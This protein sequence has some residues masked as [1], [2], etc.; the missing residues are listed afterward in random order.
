MTAEVACSDAIRQAKVTRVA[1]S[2]LR[3]LAAVDLKRSESG[4]HFVFK[5]FGQSLDIKIS[6]TNLSTKQNFPHVTFT[7]WV[8]HVV[9][10][11][12]LEQLVGVKD[13][14]VMRP[15]LATFWDRFMKL[16]PQHLI[17]DK[18][19]A[20][21]QMCVPVL[22]HGDEGRGLKKKQLMVLSM[23]GILGKG[24]SKS[25]DNDSENPF[26]PQRMNLIGNTYLTHFLQCV[27]PVALYGE[28]PEDLQHML[29]LAAREFR[30]LFENG[31]VVQKHR[32]YLCCVGIKGD[33][34]FLAKSGNFLRS[35]TRRPTRPSSKLPCVGICH[36]CLAGCESP[37]IPFE[38]YGEVAPLW[39]P[40][41][42]SRTPFSTPPSLIE[43]PAERTGTTEAL[44]KYDLFHNF[45]SG[46]GKHFTSS[47]ICVCMELLDLTIDGAFDYITEDFK[48][49]CKQHK[50]SPYHKK[51]TKALLGVEQGFKDCPDGGWSKG[52]FTRLICKWFGDYCSRH[53]VGATEDPLYLKCVAL[54]S[55]LST[56]VFKFFLWG[57]VQVFL[58]KRWGSYA[59]EYVY[60][61]VFDHRGSCGLCYQHVLER[62]VS[63]RALDQI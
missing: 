13:I 15:L 6:R 56:F 34:P 61:I 20:F 62:L 38:Q 2:G 16:H 28:T 33:A 42:G 43:I 59:A 51:L 29:G 23:H 53:V 5:K 9:E 21:R 22:Y 3:K 11:D 25:N 40:T 63:R 57:N 17:C 19:A 46:L 36:L 37:E 54:S 47:A 58:G 24:C 12:N 45:H 31:V 10:T 52:D 26:G 48:M 1:S 60:P 55:L 14:A 49:Y 32:F 8:K 4:A 18:D 30:D 50:E 41:V 27:L 39:L 44:W 7:N 35:F